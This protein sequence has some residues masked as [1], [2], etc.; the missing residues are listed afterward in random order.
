M[1]LLIGFN[2]LQDMENEVHEPTPE[3]VEDLCNLYHEQERARALS[4]DVSNLMLSS[5]NRSPREWVR[6]DESVSENPNSL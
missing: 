4:L 1:L 5:G 6:L 2:H 3:L